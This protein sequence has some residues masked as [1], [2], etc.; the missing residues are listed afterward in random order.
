MTV[1]S[2]IVPL[3]KGE[4]AESIKRTISSAKIQPYSQSEKEETIKIVEKILENKMINSPTHII[5]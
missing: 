2:A 4:A 5:P 1:A 3:L